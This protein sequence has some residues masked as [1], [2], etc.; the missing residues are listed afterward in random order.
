MQVIKVSL[1]Y[2]SET[3]NNN[4]LS[5]KL[6]LSLREKINY[7]GF[8]PKFNHGSI[9]SQGFQIRKK[10]CDIYFRFQDGGKTL[11]LRFF[12]SAQIKKMYTA[13]FTVLK[14][15][16]LRNS[17]LFEFFPYL[18]PLKR[19]IKKKYSFFNSARN[20]LDFFAHILIALH[21]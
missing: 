5:S 15:F 2:C 1:F 9:T 3:I 14:E 10:I 7:L 12:K 20:I 18:T 13:I 21:N 11:V 6:S 4:L 8:S 16:I 17:N 19:Y